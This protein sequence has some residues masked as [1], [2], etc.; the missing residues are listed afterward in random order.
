MWPVFSTGC[1]DDNHNMFKI[2]PK[3]KLR[4]V[5][6]LACSFAFTY[7]TGVFH[8]NSVAE[9]I[10]FH[11]VLGQKSKVLSFVVILL[12]SSVLLLRSLGT[13]GFHDV[14]EKNGQ[15]N[16]LCS[17]FAQLDKRVS[18]DNNMRCL[19]LQQ[20]IILIQFRMQQ[21]Y[22]QYSSSFMRFF[23]NRL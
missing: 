11:F 22:N 14:T 19:K 13:I 5:Y 17:I 2:Y 4:F 10:K 3:L 16:V 21:R 20:S 23:V 1:F 6:I 12:S 15:E 18:L 8:R 9:L 7:L